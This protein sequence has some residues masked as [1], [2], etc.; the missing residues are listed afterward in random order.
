MSNREPQNHNHPLARAYQAI[1]SSVQLVLDHFGLGGA[2]LVERPSYSRTPVAGNVLFSFG[3]SCG[4]Q[5]GDA[6]GTSTRQT[7]PESVAGGDQIQS[8]FKAARILP[9][10]IYL[11]N[12]TSPLWL[13]VNKSFM[14]GPIRI[15]TALS[16]IP[17]S[18]AMPEHQLILFDTRPANFTSSD[19]ASALLGVGPLLAKLIEDSHVA[20]YREMHTSRVLSEAERDPLTGVLNRFGWERALETLSIGKD[21]IDCSVV[22]FDLDNLKLIN[23]S[24]GHASGDRY[25]KRFGEILASSSR[26]GDLIARIGGDEFVMLAPRMPYAS[27]REFSLRLEQFLIDS[28]VSV[29]IG[30]SCGSVPSE[31]EKL[32]LEAD[33]M[34]YSNKRRKKTRALR[35]LELGVN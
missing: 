31:I 27:A 14:V 5:P 34:M 17:D 15:L 30:F 20:W 33:R 3:R 2:F 23:D 4:I 8:P 21:P 19:L 6:I 7:N 29:S 10:L 32:L 24:A 16:L 18:L 35:S 1:S 25:I 26:Q 9:T 22:V 11:A 12:S 28:G 13:E